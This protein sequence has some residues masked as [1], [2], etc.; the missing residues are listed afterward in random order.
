MSSDSERIDALRA[1]FPREGLFRDKEWKM[2]PHPFELPAEIK[3]LIARLGPALRAFQAACN[4]LYFESVESGGS[5]A[6]VSKLLDQG[7]P[8]EVV[9]LSRHAAWREALPSVIRPD[10]VMTETGV[11]ISELDS[12]PGGMGLTGWLN[13][14]YA[15]LGDDVL[16]G[17]DGMIEG[18]AAA[19]PT[20]DIL[21]SKESS[22][23]Q[24]EMEWIVAALAERELMRRRVLHTSQARPQSLHYPPAASFYRFFE[25][26]DMDNV[27]H[28]AEWLKL[29]K[30][31]R[32]NFTPPLKAFLEEKLWL[33]LF[34]T[35]QLQDYWL[36]ALGSG[37]Y[38]LLRR[39]IPEGWIVDPAAQ[40]PFSV[41][42]GLN[43]HSWEEMKAFGHK[44]RELVLKISGFS[45]KGWGSRGVFIGHDMPHH[46]WV[47]AI[48]DALGSF[49]RNP[50]L[51]QR[52]QAGRVVPHPAWNDD[53]GEAT[54]MPSRVRLCPYYF[55]PA[56]T[57]DTQ[58][59]GVLATVCPSDK[60]ILHGMRD[61]MMLPCV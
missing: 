12:L 18:F 22:D 1:A 47:Q 55:I 59:G 34:W 58:L 60:K 29:A 46:A 14:S 33:A 2:S 36:S 3:A 7:K 42:P 13:Q 45:E 11:C 32:V 43:I 38:D 23:Y 10:L 61:A 48:D 50:F 4:R 21:I 54:M 8:A 39:C 35:P 19:F 37:H 49:P 40:A 6:W 44:A 41:L 20:E 30:A 17:A 51:L 31:G 52:F 26:W 15:A 25:L 9:E 16:G 57:D 27:E 28:S 56:G 53:T 24:P 5:L